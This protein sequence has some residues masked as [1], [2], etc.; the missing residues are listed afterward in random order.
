MTVELVVRAAGGDRD[1]FGQLLM[2]SLGRMQGLARLITRDEERA[3]D[4]VQEAFVQAWR[5]LPN[6]RDP[7]SFEP[8]LRRLLVRACMR[9]VRRWRRLGVMEVELAELD[10]PIP[11]D[12]A[13]TLADRDAIE[14]GFRRLDPEQRAIVAMHYLL[15]LPVAEVAATLGLPVGT[16]KSRLHRSR[17][18]LRAALEADARTA[19]A[20]EEGGRA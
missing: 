11:G 20:A 6:L 8:W 19:P 1:A 17:D 13:L 2:G 9:E 10:V 16:V 14:R 5:D 3:R 12:A 15:D 18:A 4:A 7:S